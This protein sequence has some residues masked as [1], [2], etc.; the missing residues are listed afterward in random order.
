MRYFFSLFFGFFLF[1]QVYAQQISQIDSLRAVIDTVEGKALAVTKLELAWLYRKSKPDSTIYFS[2]E[3]MRLITEE[4]LDMSLAFPLNYLGVANHYKGDVLTSADYYNRAIEE[5]LKDKD[6]IQYAHSLN[7]LG[8]M[9]MNQGDFLKAY[10]LF[11][12]ALNTFTNYDNSEGM[13]YAYKSL[14][15]LYQSQGNWVKALEMSE[16]TLRIRSENENVTGQISVL[17]EIAKIHQV[18]KDYSKAFDYFLQAKVKAESINDRVNQAITNL[19][20]ASLYLEQ[21]KLKEASTYAN[22]ADE[23]I[24]DAQ[25]INL[26]NDINLMRAEIYLKEEKLSQAALILQRVINQTQESNLPVLNEAHKLLYELNKKQ[27]NSAS[28]L[29]HLEQYNEIHEKLDNAQVASTIERFESRLEL[30][31]RDQENELLMANQA[32]DQAIIEAQ[33]VNNWALIGISV[34]LFILGVILYIAYRKR[35]QIN[36]KLRSKNIRIAQQKEEISEQ[37]KMINE[38]NEQLIVRNNDLADLNNEKDVLVNIVAHDLKSPFNRIKGLVELLKLSQP[39]EEQLNYIN[40][41]DDI[42]KGS[43]DLIRDL[44]DVNAF[45]TNKRKPQISRVDLDHLLMQKVK[46]FYADAK[47]KNIELKIE[48]SNNVFF[49][50]DEVYLSRI[51][52]NLISNAIKFST[53]GGNVWLKSGKENGKVF[54]SVKDSGQGFSEEDKQHLYVKFKKLS[55]RPTAGESSNGLGLAIVKT[56]VERLG[57]EID[58]ES[59]SGKGSK[60]TIHFPLKIEEDTLV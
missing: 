10:D 52:D 30:D 54:L 43:T 16:K 29:M 49:E 57:G 56:L 26:L 55:A 42:T 34:F 11:R 41:L 18:K 60:F 47:S 17:M 5:A 37:N 1:S 12:S 20:I 14:S 45:E 36:M 9:Y 24:T 25:N 31:K 50:S 32:R 58:L 44:L 59:T 3:V 48:K 15:E 38:Q 27:G 23:A 22:K 46:S 33:R 8:R 28:A 4:D 19:G 51:L 2:N 6:S 13:G 7:S 35:K 21:D 53:S 40:L 39:N